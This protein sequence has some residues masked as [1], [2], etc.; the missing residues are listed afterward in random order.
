MLLTLRVVWTLESTDNHGL[1]TER[2][3]PNLQAWT[4]VRHLSKGLLVICKRRVR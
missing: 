1:S 3:A 2:L 4:H